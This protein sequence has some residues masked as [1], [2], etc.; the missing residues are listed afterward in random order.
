MPLLSFLNWPNIERWAREKGKE[1]QK[2]WDIAGDKEVQ[3]LVANELATNMTDFQPKYMRVK[4]FVIIPQ[5]LSLE[6]GELTPTMK[7]IR[8]NVLDK[9]QAWWEAIYNPAENPDKEPYIV[10]LQ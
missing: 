1:I 7:V 3:E 9:Y 10:N 4:S 8:H 6:A 5:D 2:G